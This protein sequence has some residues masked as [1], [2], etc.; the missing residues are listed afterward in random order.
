MSRQEITI[1]HPLR[2]VT[3]KI[4]IRM[5]FKL[6]HFPSLEGPSNS[7][8]IRRFGISKEKIHR[9]IAWESSKITKCSIK[10]SFEKTGGAFLRFVKICF[11]CDY[12]Q[13]TAIY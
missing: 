3:F 1:N 8:F 2:F 11:A 7:S 5:A 9:G 13:P 4:W 12:P 6:S 10:I